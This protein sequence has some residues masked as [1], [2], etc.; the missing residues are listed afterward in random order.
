MSALA[1]T[2]TNPIVLGG[3][4]VIGLIMLMRAPSGGSGN[5]AAISVSPAVLSA[6]TQMNSA[7]M[8][9]EIQLHS[10]NVA[11]AAAN[12][13]QDTAR[14]AQFYAY[15]SN[16]DDNRTKLAVE[17]TQSNAGVINS[18]ISAV[19]AQ[20]IDLQQNINRMAL[21]Y[22]DLGKTHNQT[23]ATMNGQAIQRDIAKTQAKTA[24]LS[25]IVSGITGIAKIAAGVFTGGASIAADAVSTGL[26]AVSN[27]PITSQGGAVWA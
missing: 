19:T 16:Q 18:Q 26:G 15:V 9:A 17:R 27:T 23:V 8:A 1:K 14:Q 3:G 10:D 2:L 5:T 21:A 6:S 24:K 13:A 12:Y 7:A 25:T 4:A 20:Q 22:A 11:L